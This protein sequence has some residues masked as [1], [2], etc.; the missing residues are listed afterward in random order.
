M[1]ICKWCAVKISWWRSY[2]KTCKRALTGDAGLYLQ[3]G[4]PPFPQYS[5]L[6]SDIVNRIRRD[7]EFERP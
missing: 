5:R 6:D 4:G 7:Y 1:K 2:C 3:T